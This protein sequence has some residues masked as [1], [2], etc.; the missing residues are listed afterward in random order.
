MFRGTRAAIGLVLLAA[1]LSLQPIAVCA[2]DA[3]T[4]PE[5]SGILHYISS[6]WGLLTR[7]METC[8]T[9]EDPKTGEGH[10]LY[11]PSGFPLPATL[12]PLE[13]S[14]PLRVLDLPMPITRIGAVD[15]SLNHPGGLLYLPYPY[16]VPG[17]MFN[18]MYGWDSYFIIR[19]LVEDGQINLAQ[20]M[21]ENFFFEIDH[22]GG[23]LNANRGYYL[24]RSQPPFL[25]SMILAVYDAQKAKGLANPAWLARA[26]GY[27]VKDYEFWTH[28]RHLAGDTG[29][30]R[31]YDFGS[32]PVPELG[33]DAQNYYGQVIRFFLA[34]P[35]QANSY[36]T[37]TK[38]RPA[39]PALTN[40]PCPSGNPAT[41]GNG[42]NNVES[43]QL[44]DE[45]YQGDRA[46]RESGFDV[47]FRFGPF[48]AGTIDYAP[49]CL[50]SLLFKTEADLEKISGELGRPQEA[51]QWRKRAAGR[52]LKINRYLWNPQ[53]G[54]FFDYNFKTHQQSD[55]YFA[56]TFYPL[57]V[58]LATPEQARAVERNLKLFEQPGGLVMS[59]QQTG[60]QWDYP[61]GWAPLQ[62]I[63]V[64]GLR[65]FGYSQDA[66]RLSGEFLSMVHDNFLRDGTIREKYNVVTRSSET[67]IRAGYTANVI[68]FGWTNGVFLTLLDELSDKA[69]S[70][71]K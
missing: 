33:A 2:G 49:T 27:A 10:L 43:V 48:S 60:A 40:V 17:G 23:V 12:A 45:F 3:S 8:K 7:S 36:V 62:L 6:G 63:A 26:Y 41:N 57:W 69:V 44:T 13:K 28:G 58:G 56:T 59:T 14:C 34:H 66:N 47:S 39:G 18:E 19:G 68:G 67:H 31:Y 53:R 22:Y 9:F 24:T 50:N 61:Y 54:L 52:A 42:C 46:M 71:Q 20:G 11:L 38:N 64:E 30:S 15:I 29:L 16:V 37:R 32:G 35:K 5:L 21:V 25:T 51:N 70:L 4:P 65:R 55:Y 1:S